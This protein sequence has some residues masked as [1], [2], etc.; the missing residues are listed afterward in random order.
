LINREGL[1]RGGKVTTRKSRVIL[2][3]KIGGGTK[4]KG[5]KG[6]CWGRR[7]R[8]PS[9][10]RKGGEKMGNKIYKGE[11]ARGLLKK[12]RGGRVRD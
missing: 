3:K 8:L 12:R 7:R 10:R 2:E 6:N 5:T 9:R 4:S 1:E 11:T